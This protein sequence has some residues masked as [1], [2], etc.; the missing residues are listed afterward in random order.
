MRPKRSSTPDMTRAPK[1]FGIF[2]FAGSRV[3]TCARPSGRA[4]ESVSP[5]LRGNDDSRR[6]TPSRRRARSVPAQFGR[7]AGGNARDPIGR[8]IGPL[9]TLRRRCGF[10]RL[11]GNDRTFRIMDPYG[12]KERVLPMT[13]RRDSFSVQ[14]SGLSEARSFKTGASTFF[15][16]DFHTETIPEARNELYMR[17]RTRY[18]GITKTKG[19]SLKERRPKH[20][21]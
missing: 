12:P 1:F 15:Y 11:V 2:R 18:N 6:I 16:S 19:C 21:D 17:E 3:L 10:P 5:F 13:S 9:T 7:W 4:R 8:R 20:G 14:R